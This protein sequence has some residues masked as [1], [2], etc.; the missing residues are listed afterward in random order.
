MIIRQATGSDADAIATLLS[1]SFLEDTAI[2]R[3]SI[4]NNPR[5]SLSNMYVIEDKGLSEKIAGCLRIT[6]FEICTRG[7]KSTMAGIAAVAV[8]PEVRRRGIAEALMEEALRKMYEMSYPVSMLFPFKHHFYKK[9]GY[10]YVGNMMLYEFS[11][12]N[13]MNFEERRFVRPFT[14]ADKGKVKKVLAQ[15]VQSHGSFTPIRTD[16]FWDLVVMPKFKDAYVYDSG[17]V[18][19]YVVLEFYKETNSV[20]G[21]PGGQAINIKELVALDASAH[22][23]LWGFLGALGEQVNRIRYMAPADY[24]LHAFLKEPRERDYRRLFFE[25]KTFSTLASGFMLRVINVHESLRSLR[26]ALEA[27]ADFVIRVK[28]GNL[29]QNSQN[30]NVHVHNG[31]TTVEETRRPLQFETEIGIFSQIY[32]GFLKP[33]DALRYGF[34]SGEPGVVQKLD[35]LFKAPAPFIYQYDI[36]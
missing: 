35:E 3:V 17:E 25:Y 6:P 21:Q 10:A 23:G 9:F 8:Q 18:R 20:N 2:V 19:G 15:E 11:P 12:N 5:Y 31:E 30:L 29:P 27:P 28:D 36:F 26:H 16:V 34:A 33:S 32:S 1:K 24:P 4:E 7:I 14:K 22:R 13:L